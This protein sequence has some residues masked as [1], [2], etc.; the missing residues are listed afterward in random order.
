M[1]ESSQ[2]PRI[3]RVVLLRKAS[4]RRKSQR[5]LIDGVR[6]IGLAMQS[7]IE[8]ETVFLDEASKR[9]LSEALDRSGLGGGN[10]RILQLVSPKVLAKISYGQRE[11]CPIAVAVTPSLN[12]SRLSLQPRSIV[13]V[14]DQTEKPGNLGACLRTASACG[15]GAVVLTEPVC[16]LLNPNTIRASR[17]TVF[18]LPIAVASREELLAFC[19]VADIPLFAARVQTAGE[20]WK[21]DFRSGGALVFGSEAHG[22]GPEWNTDAIQSFTIPMRGAADSLNLSISAAVTLYEAVRQ[23]FDLAQTNG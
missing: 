7:G 4:Q 18:T 5:F 13:L 12:L 23:R 3:K 17:G 15:V 11:H 8:I 20:L 10:E 19:K 9:D 14:L 21:Q 1:I 22:L 2:N 16:E 6:E